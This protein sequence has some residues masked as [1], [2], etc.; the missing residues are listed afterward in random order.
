MES[1]AGRNG[2]KEGGERRRERAVLDG[3]YLLHAP[4]PT[5]IAA[6]RGFFTATA[7]SL[8]IARFGVG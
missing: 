1:D 2:G 6:H 8:A 3:A 4:G 5:A 7:F